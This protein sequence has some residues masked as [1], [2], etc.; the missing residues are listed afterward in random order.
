[1][2]EKTKAVSPLKYWTMRFPDFM[3][4][5]SDWEKELLSSQEAFKHSVNSEQDLR[6]LLD[7]LKD[8]DVKK[9]Q[10]KFLES[11]IYKRFAK[12]LDYWYEGNMI[13]NGFAQAGATALIAVGASRMDIDA[14]WFSNIILIAIG[15]VL[16]LVG[17]IFWGINKTNNQLSDKMNK[18]FGF[19]DSP[20]E[21]SKE[22]IG[23]RRIIRILILVPL[24]SIVAIVSGMFVAEINHT[25]AGYW[26]SGI[27]AL[28]VFIDL[29]VIFCL[30]RE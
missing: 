12:E 17:R 16:A 27:G 15:I 23:A 24:C 1:M 9:K 21:R 8:F 10:G 5:T 18:R 4:K 28:I 19:A 6:H 2:D 22:V 26:V 14:Y 11:E 20:M 25:W 7:S 3:A 29:I 13:K 30:S